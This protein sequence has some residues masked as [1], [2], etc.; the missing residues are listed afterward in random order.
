MIFPRLQG[1]SNF[2][3]R[4][5]AET[6]KKEN[7][8]KGIRSRILCLIAIA[9]DVKVLYAFWIFETPLFHPCPTAK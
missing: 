2:V 5:N 6:E 7:E 8:I 3:V 9:H 1:Q 4:P